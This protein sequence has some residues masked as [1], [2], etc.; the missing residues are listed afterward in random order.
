MI[1]LCIS[2]NS[3]MLCVIERSARACIDQRWQRKSALSATSFGFDVG[4]DTLVDALADDL[5]EYVR[6]GRQRCHDDFAPFRRKHIEF[7]VEQPDVRPVFVH[8]AA[9]GAQR[10]AKRFRRIV[11]EHLDRGHGAGLL[12]DQLLRHQKED[13]LLGG[14][15]HVE[16]GEIERAGPRDV[17]D[18]RLVKAALE[19]RWVATSMISLRRCATSS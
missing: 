9:I 4:E 17:A 10:S 6:D 14:D 15:V 16:A 13:V 19:K 3:L 12:V 7:T 11:L 8:D 5:L 2:K 1:L 18:R